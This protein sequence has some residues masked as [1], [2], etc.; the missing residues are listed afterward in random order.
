MKPIGVQ[1]YSLREESKDDFDAV[2]K[3][4]A[5]IGYKG[6]EPFNLFGMSPSAFRTRVQELGM[7]V[8]SSH[9]PWANRSEIGEAAWSGK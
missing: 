9:T 1:L 2:L 6:V 3:R 4:V 7:T 8:C 5:D